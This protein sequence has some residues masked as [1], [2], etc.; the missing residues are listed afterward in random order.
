MGRPPRIDIAG[1]IYHVTARGNYRQDIFHSEADKERYIWLLA[2][3]QQEYGVKLFAF[4]LMDNHVHLLLERPQSTSLGEIVKTLHGRFSKEINRERR[5][6]GHLFQGRFYS[7]IVEED[8]YLLELTRYIHLNPVRAGMVDSPDQYRWG[9]ARTYLGLDYYPFID[10]TYL[11]LFGRRPQTRYEKY[12]AFLTEGMIQKTNPMQNIKE[13]R[14][15]ASLEF[16]KQV[17]QAWEASL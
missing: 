13:G 11:A 1:L 7:L 17:K 4:V 15:L 8:A 6:V 10:R 9:S 12:K 16:I 2:H 3:Y 14:F 5:Q